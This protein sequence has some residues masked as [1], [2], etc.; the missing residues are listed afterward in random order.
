[1]ARNYSF[2]FRKYSNGGK[3]TIILVNSVPLVDQHA[4]Y[5]SNHT[6]F[7]V[8]QY[9]GDMNLDFWPKDKWYEEY[10]KYQVLIMTSQIL[11]N[12]ITQNFIG[13]Y[14]VFNY[15]ILFGNMKLSR[16]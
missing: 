15:F 5:V 8:G 11:L 6:N 9:T 12:N 14:K 2:F 7:Q 4:K 16:F 13:E 3:I 1:M 10:D